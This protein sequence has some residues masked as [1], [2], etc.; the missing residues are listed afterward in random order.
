MVKLSDVHVQLGGDIEVTRAPGHDLEVGLSWDFFEGEKVFHGSFKFWFTVLSVPRSPFQKNP[1]SVPHSPF[2]SPRAK[3][4][5]P[6]P[7]AGMSPVDLDCS[8]LVMDFAG[9]VIDA[10]YYNNLTCLDG[11]IKHSG[12]SLTG[13]ANNFDEAIQIDIDELGPEVTMLVF[14]VN[15]HQGGNFE[16]VESAFAV[17][18]DVLG[19]GKKKVG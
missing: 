15:A 7:Y 2:Q 10:C 5:H 18:S 12:D 16:H 19:D 8:V 6:P 4:V 11:A 13:E 17:V 14:L 9:M 1:G 3:P